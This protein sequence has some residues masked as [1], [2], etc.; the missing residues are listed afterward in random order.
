V[1]EA[2]RDFGADIV[3]DPEGATQCGERRPHGRGH[4]RSSESQAGRHQEHRLVGRRVCAREV[5]VGSSWVACVE[6]GSE[7]GEPALPSGSR[8]LRRPLLPASLVSVNDD[9]M[10]A[11]VLTPASVVLCG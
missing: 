3:G 5:E 4:V 10:R 1:Q 9:V 7:L 11:A 2:P 6:G 8:E